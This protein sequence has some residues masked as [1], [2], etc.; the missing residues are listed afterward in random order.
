MAS[1]RILVL[2]ASRGSSS[3]TA[4]LLE[5]VRNSTAPAAIITT[6]ADAFFA[7]A[8][9]VA[10]EVFHRALPVVSV[11]ESEFATLQ[12]DDWLTI[13]PQGTV[14]IRDRAT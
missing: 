7:L 11:G 14:I 8:G 10:D 3:T 13:A 12:T 4:V 6:H 5:A 9:I 1:G 2:P